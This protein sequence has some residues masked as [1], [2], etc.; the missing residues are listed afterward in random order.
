MES[1]LS[2]V[3]EKKHEFNSNL[4]S[5]LYDCYLIRESII[6]VKYNVQSEIILLY[7]DENSPVDHPFYSMNDAYR[8][9]D[10]NRLIHIYLD[11]MKISEE[12]YKTISSV[13][14]NQ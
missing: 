7:T 1:M 4:L 10:V 14:L 13:L 12:E 2:Q 9:G 11:C 8:K 6:S 5:Y 3:L